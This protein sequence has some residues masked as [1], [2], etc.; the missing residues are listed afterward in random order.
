VS[1]FTIFLGENDEFIL[2]NLQSGLKPRNS[3]LINGYTKRLKGI[4]S[5]ERGFDEI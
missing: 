1:I 2:E 3:P 4:I 5:L